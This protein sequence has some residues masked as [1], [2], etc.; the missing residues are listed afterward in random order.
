VL[1]G[2]LDSVRGGF[3]TV[4][5][6]HSSPKAVE[7]SLDNAWRAFV[8]VGVR[9]CLSY[10][11][12]DIHGDVAASAAIVENRRF[13]EWCRK[14]KSDMVAGLF[15][16][17]SSFTTS[18]VTLNKVVRAA[19]EA[20]GRFHVHVAEDVSDLN[21]ARSR[22]LKTPVERFAETQVLT[23]SSLAAQC[24][25][26]EDRDYERL[27]GTGATVVQSPQ[28]NAA[29]AVG[30]GNLHRLSSLGILHG[31]GTDG[32]SS[33]LFEEFRAS[34]LQQRMKGRTSAEAMELASRAAFTGNADIATSLFGPPVGRIKPG[35][36]ADLILLDYLPATPLTPANF[37]DHL[38]AGLGRAPIRTVIING[39]VVL[40]DGIF[41]RLD[42]ARIRAQARQTAK[43]LWERM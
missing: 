30:Y 22:Y 26:L 9:G 29:N 19:K 18:E 17:D 15:G 8:D 16:I 6:Q 40:K 11:V 41:T 27:K 13:A 21:D 42:E 20:G 34:V 31:F 36:R 2:L 14:S 35:A 28:S 4:V 5:D 10:A 37:V 7:G 43:Q 12:S 25:H 24:I 39:K 1:V 38:F 32:L 3:T 23:E 33:D